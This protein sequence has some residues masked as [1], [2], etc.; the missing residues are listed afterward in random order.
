[1]STVAQT[2]WVTQ[3]EP[4]FL[5][6]DIDGRYLFTEAN[7]KFYGKPTENEALDKNV[8]LANIVMI[9][10]V[11][12]ARERGVLHSKRL[13]QSFYEEGVIWPDGTKEEFDAVIWCTGFKAHLPHLAPLN[14][15][16]NNRIETQNTQAVKEPHLWLVGYGSW[17]GFASA[18]IYGVG[19]TARTTAQEIASVLGK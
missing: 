8:S 17:T 12:E 9:A 16:Q 1:M 6:D 18:T 3:K 11:K 2:Q 13:F 19:K 14:I 15:T 7:N 5:P 10:T 4:H